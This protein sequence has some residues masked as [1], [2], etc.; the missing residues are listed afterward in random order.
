MRVFSFGPFLPPRRVFLHVYEPQVALGRSQSSR[1]EHFMM[2]RRDVLFLRDALSPS[3]AWRLSSILPDS[4]RAP[5]T[6]VKRP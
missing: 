5:T 4:S 1:T 3:A 2:R 6:S